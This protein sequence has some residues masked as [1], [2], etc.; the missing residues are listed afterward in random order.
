MKI[1]FFILTNSV[2]C[3]NTEVLLRG[4]S[5]CFKLSTRQKALLV[6][7]GY[8]YNCYKEL[9]P[10]KPKSRTGRMC[11]QGSGSASE[12]CQT[13][14]YQSQ[15]RRTINRFDLRTWVGSKQT[16][17]TWTRT[18]QSLIYGFNFRYCR[19]NFDNNRE[20]C[21]NRTTKG[22]YS[23]CS[24]LVENN[25]WSFRSISTKRGF[26]TKGIAEQKWD[27]LLKP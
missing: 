14:I 13:R 19:S 9:E 26:I 3:V 27:Q 17:K 4:G 6:R 8:T 18:S 22:L 21:S 16:K 20:G 5:K 15:T 10:L 25:F 7:H 23:R 12:L 11:S 1:Q 2:G 24:S